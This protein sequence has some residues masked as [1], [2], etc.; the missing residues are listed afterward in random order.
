MSNSG[1]TLLLTSY[2]Q[3]GGLLLSWFACNL[4]IIIWFGS[5]FIIRL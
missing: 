5:A 2:S 1:E 4:R 3:A